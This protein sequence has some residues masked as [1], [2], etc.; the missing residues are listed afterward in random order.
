LKDLKRK[1]G[2]SLAAALAVIFTC[3]FVLRSVNQQ[4]TVEYRIKQRS[5]RISGIE[6]C[7]RNL[8]EDRIRA[9]EMHQTRNQM[10]FR[11][12]ACALRGRVTDGVY[13][14]PEVLE[15]GA[16]C[17]VR[18]GAVELPEGL[19]MKL[20]LTADSL[21]VAEGE[22]AAYVEAET[23][24]G[25]KVVRI[26]F[27]EIAPDTCFISWK[28]SFSAENNYL[29]RVNSLEDTFA[30]IGK[31]YDGCL[32]AFDA[33]GRPA[34]M[35]EQD[36][37]PADA[38][39]SSLR[40]SENVSAQ[41]PGICRGETLTGGPKA[42]EAWYYL[43]VPCS[44]P[45]LEKMYFFFRL[46]LDDPERTPDFTGQALI[47]S[48]VLALMA[49]GL[50]VWL[51]SV[52]KMVRDSIL[53]AEQFKRYAPPRMR[54]L[55]ALISVIGMAVVLA[56]AA[57]ANGMDSLRVELTRSAD[58]LQRIAADTD[59]AEERNAALRNEKT[60][61]TLYLAKT[62]RNELEKNDALQTR[63]RLEAFNAILGS[64]YIM[65]FDHQGRETACSTD[66]T[67]FTLGRD[68]TAELYPF[69]RLTMGLDSLMQP[70]G[71][72]EVTGQ[73]LIKTGV[74]LK[75]KDG[76][77]AMIIA[78]DPAKMEEVSTE[79]NVAY[80]LQAATQT[81]CIS[82]VAEQEKGRIL[83]ASDDSL[84][85]RT[86]D[87]L[88]LS[89]WMSGD[90][91]MC[92][93]SLNHT[94]C[95][96]AS[97]N[98]E[99]RA[100]FYFFNASFLTR[101]MVPFIWIAAGFAAL[102]CVLLSLTLHGGYGQKA[103]ETLSKIGEKVFT[104]R[105][106]EVVTADGRSK[107]TV[108]PSAR[109]TGFGLQWSKMSPEQKTRLAL[110]LS[111]VG[112]GLGM[113]VMN[114]SYL[115]SG[116]YRYIMNGAWQ[117]GANLLALGKTAIMLCFT[118]MGLLLVRLFISA[119]CQ[120]VG[121]KGETILRMLYNLLE[122][123]AVFTLLFYAFRNFGLDTSGLL[124]AIGAITL[125]VSLGSKD[126]MADII[127]GMNI[128]IEGEYQVGDIVQIDGTKGKIIDVGIRTTKLLCQGENVK[129]INN[130]NIGAVTNLS[131]FNSWYAIEIAVSAS[132][133]VV[134]LEN[135]LQKELPQIGKRIRNIISG[136][137]YKG[138]ES[139]E[140]GGYSILLLTECREENLNNVH[141]SLNREIRMLLARENIPLQ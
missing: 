72:D 2:I 75:M 30:E 90:H 50:I 117:R 115:E 63:E 100:F 51:I 108:D 70:A 17:R 119:A 39:F 31:I 54:R 13:T 113:L 99:G 41:T 55:T 131:R 102:L 129:I 121:S 118:L 61:N 22:H 97:M 21:T 28:N 6:S 66:Y 94:N 125:A 79:A 111:L 47:V 4:T 23:D 68:E 71:T 34:L 127:A 96:G 64:E 109:W 76:F 136:P 15:G 93:L 134:W 91:P 10:E 84:T 92:A 16:V 56:A 44:I 106:V 67:D 141:R 65:I 27:E 8:T 104:G 137:V 74:R 83:Y 139:L 33:E 57:M 53:D 114:H 132:C 9:N 86:A 48:A 42:E 12:T 14:G 123:I 5:Q 19:P 120:S 35:S 36:F 45:G 89:E 101:K 85:G 87:S 40:L 26:L 88:G 78:M 43:P 81:E 49:V 126:I 112:L 133:D 80:I 95:Y 130:R 52:Q 20:K 11:L 59:L 124:G 69:R 122:Y 77:G 107:R 1:T 135:L 46:E 3:F 7:F 116:L 18:D 24:E 128:V 73:L 29:D 98:H 103:Y 110:E 138:V 58:L 25:E 105:T 32:V 82:L 62:L 60:E 37:F 140:K 38:T